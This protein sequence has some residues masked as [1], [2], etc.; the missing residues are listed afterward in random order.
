MN[1]NE[2]IDRNPIYFTNKS[3]VNH[4]TKINNKIYIKQAI[5]ERLEFINK[6]KLSNYYLNS[7]NTTFLKEKL[8]ELYSNDKE[9]FIISRTAQN[10]LRW[11]EIFEG[12]Q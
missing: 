8:N 10:I 9:S 7:N 3:N 6:L 5:N 4:K 11:I 12:M 2:T 1:T